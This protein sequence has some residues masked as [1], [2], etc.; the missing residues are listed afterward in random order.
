MKVDYGRPVRWDTCRRRYLSE[1]T[2]VPAAAELVGHGRGSVALSTSVI[3][4]D[5]DASML[6]ALEASVSRFGC[7]VSTYSSALSFLEAVP[8]KPPRV[9]IL[10]MQMPGMSGIE[11]QSIINSRDD[12]TVVLFISGQSHPKQ[13]VQSMKAGAFDFLIKPF[14]LAELEEALRKAID[15]AAEL[16]EQKLADRNVTSVFSKL[17]PR[18]RQVF[19]A[20]A[21]GSL[22]K[23]IAHDFGVSQSV[24][25]LHKARVMKKL[26]VNTLQDLVRFYEKLET[27]KVTPENSGR[28]S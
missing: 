4:V 24:I 11:A 28:S 26:S 23:N 25:K 10:D 9:L 12:P 13:I 5:D 16:H 21:R 14:S 27:N 18:E 8:T 19:S 15:R 22:V 20:L 6:E 7:Q 3:I 17:T 1:E 2:P